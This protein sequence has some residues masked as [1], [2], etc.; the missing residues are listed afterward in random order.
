MFLLGIAAAFVPAINN[1]YPL[2]A[3]GLVVCILFDVLV[4]F[5]NPEIELRRFYPLKAAL[6][7]KTDLS[8]ELINRGNRRLVVRFYEGMPNH[9]DYEGFPH[10]VSLGVA[11]KERF[12]FPVTFNQR[13]ETV[14]S[15]GHIETAS[16]IQL[17]WKRGKIGETHELKVYPNYQPALQYGLFCL[18]DRVQ[19]MGII[20]P[21]QKGQSKEFHQL[22]DYQEGDSL[23]SIDWK[24]TSKKQVLISREYQEEKDQTLILAIDTSSRSRAMDGDLPILDHL[25]NAAIFISYMALQQGDKVGIMSFG[26]APRFLPPVKGKQNLSHILNHVYNYEASDNFGDYHQWVEELH[27]KQKKRATVILLTNLRAEDQFE[28]IPALQIV[29]KKHQLLVASMK[30]QSLV[31]LLKKPVEFEKDATHYIGAKAYEQDT[32]QVVQDFNNA[33]I[34]TFRDTA[35]K[36]PIML[37]N[38]YLDM[39]AQR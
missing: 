32:D 34:R 19:Q 12:S 31:D 17:W 36:F 8:L 33:K 20:K 27:L 23:R 6:G 3:G 38:H 2:L 7:V 22:R 16:P 10:V 4:L 9:C 5:W 28:S 15:A 39:V 25:L 37:A 30:E 21:R 26:G 14:I 24:A 35:E 13:G 29:A 18:A 11:I 1:I